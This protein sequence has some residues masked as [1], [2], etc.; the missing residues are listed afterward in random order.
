MHLIWENLIKNLILLWTGEFKGLDEGSGCYVI[1]ASVWDAIGVVSHK[2]GKTIPGCYGAR[3]PNFRTDKQ[4]MTADTWSF[5]ALYL[6]PVLLNRKFRNEEYYW[7]FI[8][9]VR[10]LHLCLQF[11]ITLQEVEEIRSGFIAWVK[12]YEELYYQ[13]DP[14]R[15]STCPLTIHALLHIA[16]C[17][18]FCGPIWTYWAFP[19]ERYCGIIRPFIRSRKRPYPSLDRAVLEIAR[20]FQIGLLYNLQDQLYTLHRHR[21]LKVPAGAVRIDGYEYT[22]LPPSHPV[23]SS[24]LVEKVKRGLGTRFELSGGR[25]PSGELKTDVLKRLVA[26]T[27]ITEFATAR[28][29]NGDD[30]HAASM[31]TAAQAAERRDATYVRYQMVVDRRARRP[32]R[33]QNEFTTFYGHLQHILRIDL[34]A[35]PAIK[36]ARPSTV[37]FALLNECQ[38][39]ANHDVLDIHYY[40]KENP[41]LEP[42]D[43]DCLMC[44]VGRV[45]LNKSY[46]AII[47]RS[48]AIARAIWSGDD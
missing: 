33:S 11:E 38:L 31:L 16:D 25:F 30:L 4:S 10:L 14:A 47:D 2:A 12:K 22:L 40:Q 18:L 35:E 15:I 43:L 28:V 24:L 9:L 3:P 1:D 45:P 46:W 19:M 21:A 37:V 5:W 36:L 48:G 42:V 8:E 13:Y 20:L 32:G 6:G 44:V 29:D 7:H 23:T 34:P 41:A 26:G 39:E 17:I 27:R